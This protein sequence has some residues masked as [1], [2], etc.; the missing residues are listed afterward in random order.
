MSFLVDTNVLSEP[1]KPKP[2]KRVVTWLREP[3]ALAASKFHNRQ[4]VSMRDRRNLTVERTFQKRAAAS[5]L[6]GRGG[7]LPSTT[8][9]S[10]ADAGDWEL[11]TW[12]VVTGSENNPDS[13]PSPSSFP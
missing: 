1:A 10:K 13:Q 7:S 3:G 2:A 9:T 6:S 12:L 11:V 5:L 8:E 4:S